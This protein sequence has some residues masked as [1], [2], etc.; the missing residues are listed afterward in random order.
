[1]NPEVKALWVGAL[2]SGKYKQGRGRLH[3]PADN[4]F[5]CMGVLCELAVEAGVARGDSPPG[6][7]DSKDGYDKQVNWLPNS[8]RRWAGLKASN[9]TLGVDGDG[10]LIPASYANDRMRLD[11]NTI[12]NMIEEKL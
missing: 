6:W 12:A 11:F 10:D 4:S 9:P 3:D 7:Y 1:M 5:C 2:R 8:V